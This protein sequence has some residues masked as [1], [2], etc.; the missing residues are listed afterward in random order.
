MDGDAAIRLAASGLIILANGFFV[1]AEYALIGCRRSRVEA[2][3]RRGNRAAKLADA[4]LSNLNRTVAGIQIAITM[5]GIGAGAVAEPF[6]TDFVASLLGNA[7]DRS[8]GFAIALV[9]VTFVMVLFGELIPKYV[10]LERADR[11][12]LAVVIPLS[13]LTRL[14]YPLIWLVDSAGS[15]IL[16]PFGL[17]LKDASG[18]ALPKEELLLLI[19]AQS[20]EGAMEQ[21]H[22]DM[23]SRAL[24]LD[25][26]TA[27]DIMIHRMDIQW[28]DL[29][30]PPSEIRA[31]LAATRHT[32]IPVCRGDVD[33]VAGIV[34][35]PEVVRHWNEE[36]FSIES[37]IRPAVVV[38][39]NLSIE[40]I[41]ERM[42]EERTQI[43]IVAD[44]YGG[45][46]GMLTLE[47]VVEEIFGELEDR[48]E[49]ERAPIEV[50]ASGRVSARAD[51]RFDELVN[52]LGVELEEEP[53]TR[54]LATVFVDALESV[55]K[56]GDVVQTPLGPMRIENMA[57]TRIT[58]VSLQLARQI[59]EKI[60][61]VR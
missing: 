45:T 32:R 37:V 10:T 51:V 14:L 3:A 55:P 25:K 39:E 17:R 22:A 36:D 24:R 48:L 26:L 28:L 53:T 34:Y 46:S 30:T 11:V 18:S 59:L 41:V 35:L 9:L 43:L 23:V 29:A 47:D 27:A 58:R 42:R 40:R 38:P 13:W 7:I 5:C 12:L 31:K 56:Q 61:P 54:T 19:R 8:V 1:A 52:K 33:D 44:E 20:A 6:V 16:R 15:L 49:F 21:M 60:E 50:N 2:L 57:K 4:A